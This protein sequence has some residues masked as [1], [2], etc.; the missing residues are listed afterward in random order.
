MSRTMGKVSSSP[1]EVAAGLS[2]TEAKAG[3]S[4]AEVEASASWL[5]SAQLDSGMVPWYRGGHADPWNHVEAAMALAVAGRWPEVGRAFEWLA[6]KQLPDGSWCRFYLPDG[7]EDARR[8]PNT[9][10]YVAVGSLWC[11]LLDAAAPAPAARGA[12]APPQAVLGAAA[13]APGA[14]APGP[15]SVVDASW[16]VVERALHWCLR[17]QRP[18]GEVAWSV[19]PD[20]VASS[21]ALLAAN[22]SLQHSFKAAS[23]L[24]KRLG[25]DH[26][27]WEAA[28]LRVASAISGK[29]H[30]FAPK[31]R[32]AMDWYYPV[33]TG[34]IGAEAARE[35]LL[36]RWPEFVMEG[37]GVRCVADHDWVTAAETAECA[38]AANRAGLRRQAEALLAW[39]RHLRDPDDGAYWTGCAHPQCVRFPSGQKSTY[40]TA[41]VLIADHVVYGRSPAAGIFGGSAP[42]SL[43]VDQLD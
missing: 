14:A 15:R 36:S 6:S 5:A 38:M 12:A 26:P 40:S 31:D 23:L 34:A 41:A 19:S 22:S 1:V 25:S 8:D 33:L 42:A 11:C 9:C 2:P 3:L 7:V 10:A 35:R 4:P 16:P 17:Y 13:P 32:W 43:L 37:L 29:P 30:L 39:T 24:A 28:A 18:S 27:E 21:F 20:G